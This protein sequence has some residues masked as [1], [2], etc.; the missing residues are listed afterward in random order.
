M[1]PHLILTKSLSP[2]QDFS[3]AIISPLPCVICY[4]LTGEWLSLASIHALVS[5]DIKF[6]S[7]TT[8]SVFIYSPLFMK[9]CLYSFHFFKFC[10]ILSPSGFVS[11][12]GLPLKGSTKTP[13]LPISTNYYKRHGWNNINSLSFSSG[14]QIAK[15]ILM[16]L[17]QKF[18]Q[19]WLLQEILGN[20]IPCLFH[21]L[22]SVSFLH[23]GPTSHSLS[24]LCSIIWLRSSCVPLVR[25]VMLTPG[26]PS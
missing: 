26:P 17:K 25:T 15:V 9:V 12:P 24:S 19:F 16:G 2:Y 10:Y 14:G 8:Y 22:G 5:T 23:P 6:I 18:Q 11:F 7:L 21:L 1:Y 13:L 4:C 3:P 20:S